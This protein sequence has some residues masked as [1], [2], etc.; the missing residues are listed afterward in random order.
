M[1]L[2][3]SAGTAGAESVNILRSYWGDDQ[4]YI[5]SDIEVL[6]DDGSVETRTVRGGT[7]DHISQIQIAL[8]ADG[9]RRIDFVSQR[10]GQE[11]PLHWAGSCVFLTP[12]ARAS[13]ALTLP[14]ITAAL[15]AAANEWND[16]AGTCSYIRLVVTSPEVLDAGRDGKNV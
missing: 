11:I 3:A 8:F 2:L 7:V 6:K 9:T 4:R 13:R 1:L 10:N 12:D 15:N 5:Y 14:A 16:R